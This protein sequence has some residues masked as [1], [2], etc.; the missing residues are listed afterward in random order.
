MS[1][2]LLQILVRVDS[3]FSNVT[4]PLQ[5]LGL[6]CLQSRRPAVLLHSRILHRDRD[7]GCQYTT[8]LKLTVLS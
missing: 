4:S 3:K 1:S 2:A 7:R 8:C 6:A 5:G